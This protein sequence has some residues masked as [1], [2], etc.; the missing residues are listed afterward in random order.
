MQKQSSIVIG[1][2]LIVAGILF[3]IFQAFPALAPNIDL[4]TQ[5]PLII[6]GIGGLLLLGA[7]FGNPPLA[8]PASIVSGI[9]LILAYQNVSGNW[10]SWAYVWTLIPGF[11]GI[12]IILMALL[13]KDKREQVRDGITLLLISFGLFI[14]FGG[15]LGALG[16]YWPI[17]LIL[18]GL[19]LL[20]RSYGRTK[21]N[22]NTD[23]PREKHS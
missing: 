12:G 11:V 1:L 22:D 10:A 2:I 20:F 5:W 4:A 3:L 8:I 14:V 6:V 21:E 15:F 18:G 7:L 17:L 16:I 13:D 19:I 23:E 9:G